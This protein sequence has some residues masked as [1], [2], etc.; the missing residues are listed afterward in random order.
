MSCTTTSEITTV[1]PA[2][3]LFK[4][5]ILDWH[6][7]APKIAADKIV[8]AA[9]IEGDGGVGTVRQLNF[10]PAMPFSY[11]Q[12]RLEFLDVEKCEIKSSVVGGGGLG[13]LFKSA[14]FHVKFSP[15]GTGGSLVKIVLTYTPMPGANSTQYENRMKGALEGI[16]KGCEAFL[17][18]NPE[19]YN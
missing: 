14:S 13:V 4:A 17:L 1:I 15:S 6:N 9:N 18:A 16:M 10:G 5:A 11:E 12:R 3:R 7:L 8:S 19:A 2:P